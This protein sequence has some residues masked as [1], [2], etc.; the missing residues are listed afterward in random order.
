MLPICQSR[1]NLPGSTEAD[2]ANS[3]VTVPH[4]RRHVRYHRRLLPR[5]IRPHRPGPRSQGYLQSIQWI[6]AS[7][8]R[9]L[10]WLDRS[11]RWVL[12]RCRGRQGRP[13]IH[14]SEP[15]LRGHGPNSDF[16]RGLGPL[17]VGLPL[18]SSSRC[19]RDLALVMAN[20]RRWQTHRCPDS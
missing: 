17:R 5:Y 13:C 6:Y 4:S 2:C 19:R 10:R 7:R 1:N 3:W 16:R 11:G 8:M 20:R 15:H 12:H 14:V 18:Q 9:S